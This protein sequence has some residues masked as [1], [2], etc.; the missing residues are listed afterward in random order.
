MRGARY[1]AL[2]SILNLPLVAH[3]D[4]F[5]VWAAGK[6]DYTSGTGDI[7][8]TFDE[9]FGGGVEGGLELLGIDLWGEALI[10]GNQQYLFTVNAGFDLTFGKEVRYMIGLYTGPMFFM[11]PEQA[12]QLLEIPNNVANQL[13]A[14]Q[15]GMSQQIED[16][17]NKEAATLEAEYG[18]FATGWNLARLR[19]NLEFELIPKYL[20]LGADGM[21]GYHY[22][23]S[24]EDVA[25]GVKDQAINKVIADHA[26]LQMKEAEPLVKELREVVGAEEVDKESLDGM[27]WN[28][29]FFLKLEL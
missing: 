25:A 10:K 18:R 5:Q 28:V 14:Y 17:Y 6:M 8:K 19:M 21:V 12:A 2:L 23:I 24:G 4:I 7:Y 26:E 15:P 3:A 9:P 22:I 1:L 29:G 20:Y 11:F 27:N 13:D 16:G